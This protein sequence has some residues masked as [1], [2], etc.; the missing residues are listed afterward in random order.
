MH[1]LPKNINVSF[2]K[3]RNLT[4]ICTG[5]FQVQFNF[6]AR[7]RIH[8]HNPFAYVDSHGVSDYIKTAPSSAVI[9]SKLLGKI[10]SEVNSSQD[11]TLEVTFTTGEKLI[12]YDDNRAYEC[13]TIHHED[14]IIAV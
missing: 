7:V 3:G 8:V 5:A 2:L 10:I 12:F 14:E 13:Y 9:V 4:Q 1:G 11:G 6:D